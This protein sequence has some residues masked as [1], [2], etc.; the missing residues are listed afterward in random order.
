MSL[1]I[2]EI[3]AIET[4]LPL[5]QEDAVVFD[6]G[7]NGGV[8]ADMILERKPQSTV[9]LFEPNSYLIE[10]G[11]KQK[12]SN[13]EKILINDT[14]A[15]KEDGK[16]LDFFYFT[17]ENNGLSSIYHNEKWDYLPM[18]K[19]QV[20]SI[21]LDT[22]CK[23]KSISRIDLLKIDVE[24][25]ELD[26]LQGCWHILNGKIAKY[27]Q[28]EY[29]EHYQLNGRK[30]M[31]VVNYV[32]QF[33]YSAYFWQYGD[34]VKITEDNFVENYRLENFIL[35]F[36]ALENVT[37]HWNS[38]FIKNVTGIVP[39]C[40]L[41]IEIGCFEGVTTRYMCENMLNPGG[42]VICVDP[43]KDVYL[44]NEMSEEDVKM[45]KEYGFFNRQYFRFKK[46][47][48]GLPVELI[49]KTS[50]EALPEMF[51]YRPE[52]IFID[53][54]HRE[55]AVFNDCM[56]GYAILKR[57]GF[58]LIDDAFGYRD[59]TTRGVNRFL[60]AVGNRIKILHEGYQLLITKNAELD[61]N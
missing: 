7:A 61:R 24:G 6:V 55:D 32:K 5:I 54:D 52:F 47:T 2:E 19:G 46:N 18:Q 53:G 1:S 27:I 49:R 37:Q 60:E 36:E 22:Y 41:I 16:Q 14:A 26:V 33:G 10:H 43:L 38:E 17:N 21:T 25:A 57:G 12:Y 8:W 51:H 20:R 59:Y 42:R 31:D 3:E 34:F 48:W 50:R 29:S 28:V 45:N 40:D 13:N 44:T 56:E 9:H 11:L 39:K 15:Y 30:F 58:M 35:T 23:E 4:V